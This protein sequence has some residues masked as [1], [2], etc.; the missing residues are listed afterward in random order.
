MYRKFGFKKN[1][2]VT[3]SQG[4][5]TALIMDLGFDPN[6]NQDSQFLKLGDR[7]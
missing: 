5:D 3:L 6:F 2:G 7:I 1:T 4:Q